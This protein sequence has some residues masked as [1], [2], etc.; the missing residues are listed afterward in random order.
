M[1]RALHDL[2]PGVERGFLVRASVAELFEGHPAIDRLHRLD[3]HAKGSTAMM[4][5]ELKKGG[6]GTALLAHRSLRSSWLARRAGIE[7]RIGFLQSEA[8]L[9]LTQKV[10]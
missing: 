7:S 8:P 9:L 5:A 3:K 1:L 6:Y 10:G 2:S 4:A